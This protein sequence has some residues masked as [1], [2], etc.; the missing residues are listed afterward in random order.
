MRLGLIT[1]YPRERASSRIRAFQW[2]P[3]LADLGVDSRST[4]MGDVRGFSRKARFIAQATVL[5]IWSDLLLLQKPA[6]P[7]T[8]IRVLSSLSPNSVVDVDDAVWEPAEPGSE[9]ISRELGSRLVHAIESAGYVVAGNRNIAEW[10]E[11]R[12]P[13]ADITV[14]PPCVD[15]ELWPEPESAKGQSDAMTLGWIGSGGNLKDLQP[16]IPSLERAVKRGD[17]RLVIVSSDR[18]ELGLPF[19]FR[20]WRLGQSAKLMADWDVGIMPLRDDARTRGR[21][22]FKSVQYMAAGLPVLASKV[23]GPADVVVDEVCGLLV[24][25]DQW[26]ESIDQLR[27]PGKRLQLGSAARRH[28]VENLSVQS[29][30]TDLYGV[31]EKALAR[32]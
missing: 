17:V 9:A 5:G 3:V 28:V 32:R 1:R 4:V 22:G 8:A 11:G 26:D 19:E 15:L 2:Q 31:F 10:I 24:D 7:R 18:P 6:L 14:I 13:E 21:C 27:D 23:P 16:V 12:C 25:E 20:E 29:R 30:V